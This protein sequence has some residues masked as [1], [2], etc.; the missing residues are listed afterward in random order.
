ML[1]KA[2]AITFGRDYSVMKGSRHSSIRPPI[3]WVLS[4][5]TKRSIYEAD[6]KSIYR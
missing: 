2:K 6:H 4:P 5:G 1:S 3:K